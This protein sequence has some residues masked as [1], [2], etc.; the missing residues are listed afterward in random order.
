VVDYTFCFT[1]EDLK[2]TI[3][4]INRSG[5]DIVTITE[6]DD[7]YTVFFRRSVYG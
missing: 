2:R 4:F 7:G 3:D 5:Y 6:G 1:R